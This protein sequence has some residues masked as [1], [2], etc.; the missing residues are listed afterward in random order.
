MSTQDHN[1]YFYTSVATLVSLLSSK[2]IWLSDIRR[3]NDSQEILQGIT[4]ITAR[5]S[6]L[7]AAY[8]DMPSKFVLP[9]DYASS[10]SYIDFG[11]FEEAG[12]RILDMLKEI[13]ATLSEGKRGPVEDFYGGLGGRRCFALCFTA[14]GDRL[15]QWRGYGSDGK[16]V[17]VGF[18]RLSISRYVE[19]HRGDAIP[20]ETL[21][22]EPVYYG[23]SG[24]T[25]RTA[26]AG[27]SR[28]QRFLARRLEVS[29]SDQ[30]RDDETAA[31]DRVLYALIA[32]SAKAANGGCGPVDSCTLV[33][34]CEHILPL[35]KQP[36]FYEECEERIYV[37]G[38]PED[39]RLGA[40]A[41]SRGDAEIPLHLELK[42]VGSDG[43]Y[44]PDQIRMN[45]IVIGPRCKFDAKE[46][47]VLLENNGF[48]GAD[49][50]IVT[51][52]TTYV[53]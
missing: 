4:R 7:L 17:A 13:A 26:S 52:D 14:F 41:S 42:I 11:V 3:S 34:E 29:H 43:G 35:L 21:Y 8:S 27:E 16:G 9:R 50:A 30:L 37:W 53:G 24:D 45:R 38:D 12:K 2:S 33:R 51:S 25:L 1:L 47:R 49:I 31:I 10:A 5:L 15:S 19:R 22:F 40:K 6:T 39:K 32:A 36:T 48:S 44:S 28:I 23:A 46:L 18:D 20:G